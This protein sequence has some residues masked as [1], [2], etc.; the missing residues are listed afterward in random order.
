METD[1]VIT[2]LLHRVIG[3]WKI[4]HPSKF[5][6]EIFMRSKV[7]NVNVLKF[8][9]NTSILVPSGSTSSPYLN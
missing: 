3:Y 8:Q 5:E 7:M 2:F 4:Y 1:D 9:Q 6:L